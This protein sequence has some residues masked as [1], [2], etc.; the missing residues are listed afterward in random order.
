M[1]VSSLS[2]LHCPDQRLGYLKLSQGSG[3]RIREQAL[4]RDSALTETEDKV[5]FWWRRSQALVL[6]RI[7]CPSP[8][9][10][11]AGEEGPILVS[12]STSQCVEILV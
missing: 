11:P 1:M 10:H 8:N 3:C 4:S 2:P 6:I 5:V 7:C 12:A 9:P